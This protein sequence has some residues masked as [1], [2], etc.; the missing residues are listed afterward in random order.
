MLAQAGI[1]SGEHAPT[2]ETFTLAGLF[3]D[4]GFARHKRVALDDGVN[5]P[6]RADAPL[7]SCVLFNAVRGRAAANANTPL[8]R[9]ER[10]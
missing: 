5:R 3:D 10:R 1:E 4:L 6:L 2:C 9:H 7:L 8:T